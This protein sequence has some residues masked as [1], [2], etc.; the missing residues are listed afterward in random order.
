MAVVQIR[1]DVACTTVGMAE[2]GKNVQKGEP[3]CM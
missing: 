1:D 3:L 2:I